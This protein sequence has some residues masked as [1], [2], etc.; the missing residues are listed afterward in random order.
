MKDREGIVR[1][2]KQGR[3]IIQ[4]L[5]RRSEQARFVVGV[6]PKLQESEVY[7]NVYI[8]ADKSYEQRQQEYL[9]R[10]ARRNGQ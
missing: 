7:K 3:V 8:D 4:I 2:G 5:F 9:E 1:R 6:S 10:Q